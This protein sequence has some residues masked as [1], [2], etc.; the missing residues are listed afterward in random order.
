MRSSDLNHL[1]PST[2]DEQSGIEHVLQCVSRCLEIGDACMKLTLSNNPRW[3][4]LSRNASTELCN[5]TDSS[6]F[7]VI[8]QLITQTTMSSAAA[9]SNVTTTQPAFSAAA[10]FNIAEGNVKENE[11]LLYVTTRVINL[12]LT[13][14]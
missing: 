7:V 14:N 8:P 6:T 3:C 13:W 11:N 12:N 9:T 1:C 10:G 2:A 4:M 5:S